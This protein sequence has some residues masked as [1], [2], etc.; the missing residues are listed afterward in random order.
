MTDKR[1]YPLPEFIDGGD[2]KI[3]EGLRHE[4]DLNS[5]GTGGRLL[6]PMGD[7]ERDRL[8]KQRALAR[9][10]WSPRVVRGRRKEVPEYVVEMA[11]ENRITRLMGEKLGTSTNRRLRD[12]PSLESFEVASMAAAGMRAGSILPLA[13]AMLGVFGTADMQPLLDTCM[14]MGG[15]DDLDDEIEDMEPEE[16]AAMEK[17]NAAY[18]LAFRASRMMRS[19]DNYKQST[20]RAAHWLYDQARDADEKKESERKQAEAEKPQPGKKPKDSEEVKAE[21]ALAEDIEKSAEEAKAKIEAGYYLKHVDHGTMT[22]IVK[23]PLTQPLKARVRS[24]GYRASDAGAVLRYPHRV[25][26]DQQVFRRRVPKPG[27]SLLID[28]SGSMSLSATEIDELIELLPA[29]IIAGYSGSMS[30]DGTG[31][32]RIFADKG[33]R[34]PSHLLHSYPQKHERAGQGFPGGN[35]IDRDALLWLADQKGPRIWVCDAGV[36]GVGDEM[37]KNIITDCFTLVRKHKIIRA[38]SVADARRLAEKI[39]KVR[40]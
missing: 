23:M 7:S 29:A 34:C 20:L 39:A 27:G 26:T 8:V 10:K 28:Q 6:A 31:D 5:R 18:D 4:V 12:T 11:E 21:E 14:H 37:A 22:D 35:V 24:K 30:S 33:K 3:E 2:W 32:L 1:L 36:T 15:L 38:G 40:G 17:I 25:V 9:V 19:L 16:R 13:S